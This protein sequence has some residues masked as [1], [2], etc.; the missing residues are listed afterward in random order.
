[1]VGYFYL[2]IFYWPYFRTIEIFSANETKYLFIY[3]IATFLTYTVEIGCYAA[4]ANVASYVIGKMSEEELLVHSQKRQGTIM[5]VKLTRSGDF[6]LYLRKT[7]R[8]ITA[9]KLI[10]TYDMLPELYS[11]L[12][13]N[14][15]LGV[16]GSWHPE[17]ELARLLLAFVIKNNLIP[18]ASLTAFAV[19]EHIVA[20]SMEYSCSENVC[21]HNT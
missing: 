21:I 13:I 20:F 1:L 9:V 17:T 11:K 2:V 16:E 5:R 18:A 7:G 6:I 19:A 3:L 4:Y 12:N 15:V 8:K 10:G 14:K